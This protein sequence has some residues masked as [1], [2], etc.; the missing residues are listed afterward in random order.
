MIIIP[1]LILW[2]EG[3]QKMFLQVGGLLKRMNP[4][5]VIH[6]LEAAI[7]SSW[8]EELWGGERIKEKGPRRLETEGIV[9]AC[10]SKHKESSERVTGRGVLWRYTAVLCLYHTPTQNPKVSDEMLPWT[11]RC[12]TLSLNLRPSVLSL[13]ARGITTFVS[14]IFVRAFN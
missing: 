2:D 4:P 8:Q 1:F 14:G 13:S 10:S 11:Q 9:A 7:S 3:Q 6:H 5:Q 12:H